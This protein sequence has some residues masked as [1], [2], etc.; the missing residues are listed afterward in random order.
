[1][2]TTPHGWKVFDASMPIL[3]YEY[4]F[5]PA[6]ANA[7]AVGGQNGL[8]VVSP[9][10]RV[11]PGVFDGLAQY[12]KVRALVASNAF[13]HMG[14]AAWKARF[15]DA[16]IFAPAQSVERVEKHSKLSGI[17]ALS[18]AASITGPRVELVDMPHY[19]TG[20]V[21]VRIETDRGLAWYVTDCIMNLPELPQNPLAKALFGLSGS[22]PGL[23]LNNIAPLFMVKNK[24]AHRRWLAS[25]FRK[26]PPRW[27]I[28][29]HGDIVDFTANPEAG[30]ALFAKY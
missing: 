6:T 17:R 7:L 2:Q 3:V 15:P 29:T 11:A 19:K 12:G 25:E 5:G 4:S 26:T 9:P 21:L 10:C 28:A 16:E 20:E 24:K 27:L 23:K 30:R 1:M 22:A 13:H 8:I 18:E 14:L